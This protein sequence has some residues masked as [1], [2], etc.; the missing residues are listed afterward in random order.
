MAM[1]AK[2]SADNALGRPSRTAVSTAMRN[3]GPSPS[4]KIT[5]W[6]A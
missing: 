5:G 6:G 2:D 1:L 3:G 4:I